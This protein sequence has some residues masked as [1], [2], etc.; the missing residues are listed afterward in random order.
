MY[1]RYMN[2]PAAMNCAAHMNCPPGHGEETDCHGQFENWPRNDKESGIGPVDRVLVVAG[3]MPPGSVIA[4]S[5]ATRQ[6]ATPVKM[7]KEEG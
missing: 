1:L 7:I 6:S 5:E 3:P 2:W 4:R